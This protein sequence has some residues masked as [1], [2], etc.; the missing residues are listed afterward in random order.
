MI[1]NYVKVA[2]RNLWKNKGTTLINLFGLTVGMTCAVLIFLWVQGQMSYDKGQIK[3]DR[4]YRLENETWVVMP[5]WLRDSALVFPEV[6]KAVRFYFWWE[7]VVQHKDYSFTLSDFALVDKEV[8][9]VFSFDFLAGKPGAALDNPYSLVLTQSTATRLFGDEDPMGQVIR[10]DNSHDFT[11]TG[12]VRDMDRFH[13]DINAFASVQDKVR[14]DGDDDFLTSQ[15]FN[16]PIYLLLTPGTDIAVLTAKIDARAQADERYN[17]DPILLRPF[18]DIYFARNLQHEHNTRHGNINMVLAFSLIAFLILAVACIN[19][20]NLTIARTGIR[21]KEIAVRKVAGAQRGN[22]QRQFFGETFLQVL[23]AAAA[24][25]VMTRFL[26][27][28]FSLLAGEALNI[29]P[30]DAGF[31]MI[32]LGVILFTTFLAGLYPSFYRLLWRRWPF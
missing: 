10:L 12:V 1:K 30:G 19:F 9:E 28:R 32:S 29:K 24:A 3:A 7:P 17:S 11:I 23:G 15:N 8:F 6:E 13:M 4:I 22:L 27:P 31:V 21:E 5:P 2:F 20:I 25:L 14:M 26:L 16:F 18:A